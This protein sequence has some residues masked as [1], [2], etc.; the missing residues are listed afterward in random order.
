MMRSLGFLEE[1]ISMVMRC[2]NSVAYVVRVN[3]LLT[4]EIKP[5][6]GIRQGNPLSPFLFLICSEWLNLKVKEYQRRRK[7]NG[8]KVYRGAPEITHLLFVDD[9][10]FFLRATVKNAENLKN[11][12]EENEALSGQ[13]VNLSKSEIY[14]GRNVTEN[15]KRI[16]SATRG[17]RQVESVSK[18]LGLPIA[19]GQNRTELFK[20]II[21]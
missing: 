2:I 12:L 7:L 10:M 4:E 21:G 8:V 1:W 13:K 17:V 5:G 3:E 14:F 18:Y 15:D 20:D 19:F 9:S 16:I 11:I 6:R